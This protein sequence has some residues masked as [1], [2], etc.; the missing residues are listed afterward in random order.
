[1]TQTVQHAS[2]VILSL[3]PD[4]AVA[5][6]CEGVCLIFVELNRPGRILPG[7]L[8]LLLTLFGAASLLHHGV[9]PWA[10]LVFL[11]CCLTLLLNWWRSLPALVLACASL[12]GIVSLRFLLPPGSPVRIHTPVAILCAGLLG[13]LGAVLTRVACR[14][15]RAKALD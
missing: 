1:M 7:A 3:P 14:A 9:R 11:L 15:R 2:R 8:G 12:L 5:L 4:L 6:A 10:A 13:L